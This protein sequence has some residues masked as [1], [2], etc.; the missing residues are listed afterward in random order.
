M[1]NSLWHRG[2]YGPWDSLDQNSGVGS[3]SL[4]QG[5]CPTRGTNPGLP[6]CRRFLYQ[7]SHKGSP[8][9]LEWVAYPFSSGYSRPRNQ[10]RVFS[11]ACRFF[12]NWAIREA[13]RM[14]ISTP[15]K[16]HREILHPP[17]GVSWC[18]L[19]NA[20]FK[21]LWEVLQFKKKKKS[22]L[23]LMPK[24]VFNLIWTW[25]AYAFILWIPTSILQN[26]L[27]ESLNYSNSFIQLWKSHAV[28]LSPCFS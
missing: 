26:L 19:L 27:Q 18:L 6:H 16:S 17:L 21:N 1:S 11:I 28:F 25:T 12:T 14:W 3:L 2:L 20:H 9:I 24:V 10:T 8:R 22:C 7:L 4:L 23:I 15:L 13:L 5:I